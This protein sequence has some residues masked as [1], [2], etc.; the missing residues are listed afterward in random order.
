MIRR[1]PRSTL[2]PYTTLFRSLLRQF[3]APA[4]NA[5]FDSHNLCDSRIDKS[6]CQ[7]QLLPDSIVKRRVTP[8]VPARFGEAAHGN[9]PA[10]LRSWRFFRQ[11][12]KQRELI[13]DVLNLN[14]VG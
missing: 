6:K 7:G 11:N 10:M 4:R 5:L 8:D 1:P 14:V 2:F 13:S 9:N 12:M 3:G